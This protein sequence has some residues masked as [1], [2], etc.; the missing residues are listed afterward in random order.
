MLACV[1]AQ[2]P[3]TLDGKPVSA[4]WLLMEDDTGGRSRFVVMIDVRGLA[5]GMH[6]LEVAQPQAERRTATTDEPAR[7]WRIPF[8]T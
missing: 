2:Q 8:W 5:P 1:A 4:P 6:V 3:I 7:P